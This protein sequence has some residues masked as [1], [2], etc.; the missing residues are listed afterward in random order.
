VLSPL[1]TENK[2]KFNIDCAVFWN[3][4]WIYT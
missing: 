2:K 3:I 1:T 4:S